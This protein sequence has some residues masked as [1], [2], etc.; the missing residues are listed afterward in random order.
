MGDSLYGIAKK[1]RISIT[2]LCSANRI[3]RDQ[4]IRPGQRLLIPLGNR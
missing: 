2:D 3:G 4:I 1:Y